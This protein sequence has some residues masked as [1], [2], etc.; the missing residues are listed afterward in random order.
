MADA[1]VARDHEGA[2]AC[3]GFT[4]SS[5]ERHQRHRGLVPYP[6]DR[7]ADDERLTDRVDRGEIADKRFWIYDWR[8]GDWRRGAFHLMYKPASER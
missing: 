7:D 1:E 6:E 4:W 2:D 8:D 5:T 3:D